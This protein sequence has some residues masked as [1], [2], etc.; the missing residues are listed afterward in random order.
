MHDLKKLLLSVN[1]TEE[2]ITVYF[3]TLQP[4]NS[5]ILKISQHTNIPRT[6]VYVVIENLI[7]K[8]FIHEIADGKKKQYI[9]AS[10]EKI[11][12]Y[13]QAKKQQFSDVIAKL[14]KNIPEI[15]ALYNY[16]HDKPRLQYYEGNKAISTLL[17]QIV[18]KG[19]IYLHLMSEVGSTILSNEYEKFRSA[20]RGYMV[21]TR[22][23]VSD[24]LTDHYYMKTYANVRNQV[25]YL[26]AA[27]GT[28]VDY[29]IYADGIIII[30][31]KDEI[32]MAVCIEDKNIVQFEKVRFNLL[33][34]HPLLKEDN[35]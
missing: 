26:P 15:Q 20:I 32:A 11:I 25:R 10:P 6:T 18:V 23:I 8:G 14:Q 16:Y 27:Y 30:T 7:T 5:T 33:W 21:N 1:L 2:E 4:D 28:N 24:T 17:M 35:K 22:E 9:P 29:I 19:D 3:A 34:D 13:V 12:N 31:Y